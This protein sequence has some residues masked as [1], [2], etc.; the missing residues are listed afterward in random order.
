MPED[1]RSSP[2]H[3]LARLAAA[4][5]SAYA[6][7]VFG[8]VIFLVTC[9]LI[10]M[11]PGLGLRRAVGRGGVHLAMLLIG[12]P[13][14]VSGREHLPQEACV[15][16][17]NHASYIDGILLTA[18]LPSRFSFVVQDGAARWPY[19]GRVL[20]R[21]GV[22]FINRTSP[23]EGSLQTRQ[24]IRRLQQGQSLTIFPEG[25]FVR[26]PGLL[27]FKNGAFLIADRATRPVVPCVIS[28]T[29]Q[30]F[31]EG[32]RR[33]HWARVRIR[34]LPSIAPADAQSL[35]QQARAALLANLDEITGA[36]A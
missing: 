34:F 1:S 5:Y 19:I 2:P 15:V 13:L 25:T 30:L 31:G 10:L 3:R 36:E 22:I 27:P 21:M 28:G 12:V 26:A 11:L 32:A 9:P 23:R 4:V 33:L 17:A 16:V 6:M 29:R 8:V 20:R 7:L 24:L 18:V 14:R 35:H